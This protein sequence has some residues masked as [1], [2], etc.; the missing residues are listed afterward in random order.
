MQAVVNVEAMAL[1]AAT[2]PAHKSG[3]TVQK[4]SV[5]TQNAMEK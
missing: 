5:D 3:L 2:S 1:P 4:Y